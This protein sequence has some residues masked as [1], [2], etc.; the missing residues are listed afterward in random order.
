M[1]F[2]ST[3]LLA[4]TS[5]VTAQ[6]QVGEAAGEADCLSF[7]PSFSFEGGFGEIVQ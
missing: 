1:R 2:L 5:L 7:W 6:L 4:L 3:S